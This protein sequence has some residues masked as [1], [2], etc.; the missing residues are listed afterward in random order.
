MFLQLH[1]SLNSISTG[2]RVLGKYRCSM[3]PTTL[4][5]LICTQDWIRR[6]LREKYI[7]VASLSTIFSEEEKDEE[8]KDEED[9]DEHGEIEEVVI[10]EI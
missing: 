8:H 5:S 2:G 9:K 1:Q 4:E 10:R 6:G 7:K 3:K